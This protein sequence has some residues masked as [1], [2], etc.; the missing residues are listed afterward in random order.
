MAT[1][2][3]PATAAFKPAAFEWAPRKGGLG[4]RGP[5]NGTAQFV[6][7][8][9]ERWNLSVVLPPCVRADA[10]AREAFI[11]RL[12]GGVHW[13]RIYRFDRPE[14]VGTMRGSPTLNAQVTRGAASLV[15]NTSAGAT[16]KAGD[17]FGCGGQLFQAAD[18][19]TANG[20]GIMTV[21]VVHRVRASIN[22]GTAIVWSRPTATYVAPNL[23]PRFAHTVI[24]D[25]VPID[26]EEIW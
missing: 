15:I 23:Q 3:W 9:S 10:G 6:D 7:L 21:E 11:H 2:D 4:F 8:L 24:L 1:Y 12:S 20:S 13:V 5:H 19:T 26:L 16:L 25:A 22:G 14:P 18:V 17:M